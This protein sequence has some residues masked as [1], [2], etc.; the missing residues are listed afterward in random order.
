MA[1]ESR[2]VVTF[3]RAADIKPRRPASLIDGLL[4][5]NTTAALIGPSGSCKTFAAAEM[6]FCVSTGLPYHGRKVQ[7]G[8]VFYINAE[9]GDGF[10]NRLAALEKHH[11]A[12]LGD[13]LL[14]VS[15]FMPSLCDESVAGGIVDV[16]HELAG[17]AFFTAG[18]LEPKLVVIDTVARAMSGFNENSAED[19]GR[20]ITSMDAIRSPWGATVLAVHHMGHGN[21]GRARGS[22]AFHASIDTEL[23]MSEAKGFITMRTTKAKDWSPTSPLRFRKVPIE[24]ATPEAGSTS[25]SSLVLVSEDAP[26]SRGETRETLQRYIDSGLSQNAAADAAGVS[27]ATASRLLRSQLPD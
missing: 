25:C 7:Q 20:L 5:E 2:H 6:A 15:D 10:R 8:A 14:F 27:R 11:G 4:Y 12:S 17:P 23:A 13:A 24:F 1:T 16:I 18:A 26:H 9:G 21:T 22:S 19:M 3:R